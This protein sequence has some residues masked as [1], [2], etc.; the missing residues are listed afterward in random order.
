MPIVVTLHTILRELRSELLIKPD[1]YHWDEM[2][3]GPGAPP[4]KTDWAWLSIYHGVFRTMDGAVYR[5]GVAL[6]DLHNP[7]RVLG[8]G[9]SWILQGEDLWKTTGTSTTS[10]LPAALLQSPAEQWRSLGAVRTT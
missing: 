7:A 9:D 4:I 10:Y 8:V 6:H 5:L 2:K 3:I 1:P